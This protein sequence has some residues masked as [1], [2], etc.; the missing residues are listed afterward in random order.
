MNKELQ[1]AMEDAWN[2]Q[3]DKY[4]QWFMLSGEEH[5]L[6]TFAYQA[7]RPQWIPVDEQLPPLGQRV[8]G[9]LRGSTVFAARDDEGFWDEDGAVEF[10][11]G[12]ISHWMYV[13]P[14]PDA[15]EDG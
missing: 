4:N 7:A 8:L 2:E 13:P 15:T 9:L 1:R 10:Y 5:E 14:T 12:K 3:A 6:I 11:E